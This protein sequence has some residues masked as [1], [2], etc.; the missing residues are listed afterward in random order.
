MD[1]WVP[2]KRGPSRIGG[3]SK[4]KKM[5]KKENGTVIS[6]YCFYFFHVF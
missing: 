4:E 3:G 1:F 2:M 6:A 5:P